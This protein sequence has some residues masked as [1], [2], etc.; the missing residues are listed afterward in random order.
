MDRLRLITTFLSV[1]ESANFSQAALRLRVSPQAV[2]AQISQL[3]A[4]LGVRLFNRTTRRVGLTEEGRMFFARCKG[5]LQLIEQGEIELRD[6]LDEAVG[7]VRLV[8]SMSLGQTLVASLVARFCEQQPR[9]QVELLTQNPWPDVVDLGADVGVVGG[10]LPNSSLIA[11]QAGVFRHVLCASPDYLRREGM[12]DSPQALHRHRCI[13]L[14]H[15]RTDRIW[16][17]TFQSDGHLLT[18]EPALAMLTH[19]PAVQRQLVLQGAGIAQVAGYFARPHLEAGTL[20][21]VPIGYVGPPIAVHVFMP[22]RSH[23]PR[24]SRLLC[25]FL[26]EGLK[27]Q[28]A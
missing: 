20:V 24:K 18:L 1:A 7:S 25:D 16:P 5:G 8:T 4:W 27:A 22:Q 14:R 10:A 6:R 9:I 26:F 13:G 3:E 12:P 11:R 15:P 17:W 19:D 23:V 21:E 28:M 2:S